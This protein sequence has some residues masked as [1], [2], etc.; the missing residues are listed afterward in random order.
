MKIYE[1]KT[2][3]QEDVEEAF[4]HGKFSD[5]EFIHCQFLETNF[6]SARF[7]GCSFKHCQLQMVK[8]DQC[9]FQES[10]FDEVKI[11]G[12]EFYKCSKTLF[13]IHCKNSILL[14]C[15]FSHLP[16]KKTDFSGS[17]LQECFFNETSLSS[18]NFQKTD[19][20]G[21]QFHHSDLSQSDFRGAKNYAI[22]PKVNNLKK[23]RF[24]LPEALS[25]LHFFG[26]DIS[27]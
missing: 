22:D 14:S 1:N 13:S 12:G 9:Y 23:A 27:D 26:I 25:F 3:H 2:F 10:V 17:K 24:H 4:S 11:I 18:S 8:M 19:L 21:T 5:C 20:M 6:R 15:N 16:M 7:L